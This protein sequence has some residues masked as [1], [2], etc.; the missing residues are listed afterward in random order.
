MIRNCLL[1][2][3]RALLKNKV[4][5]FINIGGLS[6]G[7][8]TGI[9]ILLLIK[10]EISYDKFQQHLPDIF[11]VMKNQRHIDGIATGE[12]TAGPLAQSLRSDMPEIKYACRLAYFDDQVATIGDKTSYISGAYAEP[13]IFNIMTLPALRGNPELAIRSG[14]GLVITAHLAKKLFG[15]EDP[16]GKT[17]LINGKDAFKVDAVI[18]DIPGNSSVQFDMILPFRV[19]ATNNGWLNKWDD[20]RIQTWLRLKPAANVAALDKKMTQLLQERSNDRSVSLFAYPLE[21]LRLWGSFSNGKPIGGRIGMVRMM[22]L[23]G[24]FILLLACINFMNIATARSE[25][26][27]REVGVR[28]VLGSSRLAIILQF[29]C[30]ALLMAFLG[31][32]LAVLFADLALPLLNRFIERQLKL[33]IGSW[34]NVLALVAIGLLTG[35][36]AGSYPALYLSSFK[37]ARVLKPGMAKGARGSG[38]RRSLV[39]IQFII[40]ITFI[41]G[42]IIIYAQIDHVRNRPLGYDQE[43]LIDIQTN[44]GLA[45]KYALFRNALAQI[46]GVRK[47]TAASD[48]I[49]NFGAGITGMDWPGKRPGEELNVLVTRVQYDWVGAMGLQLE[50]GRDFD[51]AYGTDTSACLINQSTIAKM[52]LKEP[53]TG[54]KIGGKTVIG[55]FRNF[56]FNNPSGIIAPMLVLLDTGRL[57]HFYVRYAN[58]GNWRQTIARLQSTLAKMAPGYP[59]TFSFTKEDFQKR[60]EEWSGYGFMTTVFGCMAIFI[61]CLGLFGLSAFIGER[62]SK[63]MSIRKVFGATVRNVWVSLTRDFLKPVLIALL[64]VIPASIW[65]ADSFL[66]NIAYHT[67]LKWWMF[68]AAAFL[69]IAIA[70]LTIS[71]HGVRTAFENPADRLRN[72]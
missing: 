65:I 37:A 66:A 63:E 62:R 57:S 18:A 8:A 5:S 70:L 9:L 60:F 7:L 13:D 33:D 51:R 31:L 42:T 41:I 35:I 19:F 15:N 40:S 72:E 14:S 4:S 67:Q 16:I 21:R 46:P 28:K 52:G 23:L 34:F 55:V 50:E 47:T 53:V 48:N 1:T 32:A 39:T 24:F 56:V 25:V 36:A 30:E 58:D 26:R 68:A 6:I 44:A 43:N 59:V 61:S 11:L 69:T 54:I 12:S 20:N 49:L 64:V 2:A 17:M 27:A 29:M 38:F 22:G 3:W 10:D 45:G 71:Y